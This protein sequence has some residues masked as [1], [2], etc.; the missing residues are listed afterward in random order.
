MY[1]DTSLLKDYGKL[2][3]L[4]VAGLEAGA[5]VS[6]EGKAQYYRLRRLEVFTKRR[7]ARYG[8]GQSVGNR[9]SWLASGMFDNCS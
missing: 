1:F 7:Q 9:F 5:R 6:V 8:M 3:R 4:D 2:A